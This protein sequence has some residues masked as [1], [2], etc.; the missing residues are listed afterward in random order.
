MGAGGSRPSGEAE[1]SNQNVRS[2]LTIAF[3]FTFENHYRDSVAA[4][5]RQ[6]VRNIVISVQ[7]VATAISPSPLGT[8]LVPKPLPGSPE[9][10]TLALW[11]CRS[12]RYFVVPTRVGYFLTIN[13][14]NLMHN[15]FKPLYN[16]I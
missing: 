6:Y 3:Q 9:A 15:A 10:V 14:L 11:I 12:Y 16:Y 4:M 5:A 8:Q 13:F 2:L 1:T 7:K